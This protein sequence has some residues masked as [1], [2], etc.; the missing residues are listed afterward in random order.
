MAGDGESTIRKGS[1]WRVAVWSIAAALW[2]APLVAMQ[3]R[4]E[5]NWDETD[6]I[7]F[8]IMIAVAAGTLDLAARVSGNGAYRTA[9]G[10]AVAG[11]FL[12]VWMNLAVGII[13]NE[14][15]PLNL[16]Y[17]G[18]L[19]VGAI[20][21]LIARFEPEGMARTL[22]AMAVAQGLVAVVAQTAGHFTW[23]LTAAY[24]ALWLLSASLFRKSMRS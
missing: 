23:V 1:R 10:I 8:G 5:M 4:S 18:V 21:A 14:E 12:L 13:G 6:F 3:F 9:I 15:N 16:M 24:V 7:V 2:L 19:A 20:G 17:G 22:T 11:G